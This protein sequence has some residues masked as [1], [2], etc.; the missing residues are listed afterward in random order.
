MGRDHSPHHLTQSRASSSPLCTAYS[1]WKDPEKGILHGLLYKNKT[2]QFCRARKEREGR[3]G[4]SRKMTKRS[5]QCCFERGFPSS[6]APKPS[7]NL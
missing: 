6:P 2:S 4:V 1:P 5:G 3:I 7:R